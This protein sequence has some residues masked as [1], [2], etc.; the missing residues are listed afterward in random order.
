MKAM[1][2]FILAL[3]LVAFAVGGNLF[4]GGSKEKTPPAI[5]L[6]GGE[7]YLSPK[8]SPGVKDTL[9]IPLKVVAD[10]ANDM[11]IKEYRLTIN[12]AAG[13]TVRE[14]AN[15][16]E[17]TPGFFARLFISL[18]FMSK[19]ALEV[20]AS[21]TWDGKDSAGAFVPDGNYTY[22]LE[23]W[24]DSGV[25]TKSAPAKLVV[26][27]TP[28]QADV[29]FAYKIFSPDGDGRKDTLPAEMTGTAETL[30][31]ATVKDKAGKDAASGEFK[32]SLPEIFDWD[33]TDKDGKKLP[34]GEYVL[35]LASTDEAGNSFSLTTDPIVIDTK[36]RAF[37]LGTDYKAFSRTGTASR[38]R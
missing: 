22:V 31:K 16:D 8:S 14:W 23:A 34:D 13:K 25:S 1:R 6:G 11:V 35:T 4:A 32:G 20:P 2:I 29:K 3:S 9:V 38:I 18:G 30:W 17:T 33:G 15:K 28:P 5:T 19:P 24:D 12:D 10:K 26:D 21:I 36:P 7:T 37:T 27:N